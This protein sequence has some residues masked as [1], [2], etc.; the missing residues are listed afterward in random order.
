MADI[1][2][3][4]LRNIFWL[5]S[6]QGLNYLVPLIVLPYLVRILGIERYGMVAFA[7]SLAQY[8]VLLTDYGFN[9]SATKQI[10]RIRSDHEGVTNLFWCVIILK[11]LLMCLGIIILA[12]LVTAIP[13]FRVEPMLYAAAYLSVIGTVL[14]PTWLFQGLEQMKYISIVSGSAKL[15]S[16]LA[17]FIFVHKSTDYVLALSILSGGVLAAGVLG[18][19]VAIRTFAISP[20]LPAFENV[21]DTLHDGW[22]LF[23]STAAT[24]FYTN[25][26]VFLVGI[27]AGNAQAGYFSA[28]EKI[29]RGMQAMLGPVTQAI[30]PHVNSLMGRSRDLALTFLRRGFIWIAVLSLFPSILLFLFAGPVAHLVVGPTA[31]SCIPIFRWMA[32]LPFIV[33][34]SNVLGIQTMI[35]FGLERELSRIYVVAGLGS[36]ALSIVLIRHYAALGAA[37]SVLAVEV[38]II[39]SMW[40]ALRHRGLNILRFGTISAPTAT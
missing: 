31:D 5:F 18:F 12:V 19:V 30:Y 33:A 17:V 9:L 35:P 36:L 2:H 24:S 1:E 8:F 39:V 10:A 26:N 7:Q 13:R 22:H 40:A 4:L 29:V 6:L 28:A 20:R 14:F 32:M 23:I 37:A 11:V 21:K 16:A 34:I 3:T 38:G 27:I 25:S 15:V